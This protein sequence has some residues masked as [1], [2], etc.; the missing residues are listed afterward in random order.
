MKARESGMPD[1]AM[2]RS[3]FAP[4]AILTKLGLTSEIQNVADFGCGYGTFAI[5]AARRI[6]GV[7]FG[8][9]IDAAMIAECEAR[10]CREG[11]R[12]VRFVL[13]DFLADGTGLEPETVEYAMLFNILHVDRPVQLL[14]EAWRI[15][16][17]GGRVA[18]I[19]WNYD[20]HTPRGPSMAI[21]PR[22]ADCRHWI[23]EAGYEVDN[24]IV[25]L[26]P[27]HYGL[28]GRKGKHT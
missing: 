21:R 24:D 8:F 28:C 20:E 11:L 26:P 12:N 18:A 23:E 9:D 13:R 7:L 14:Q 16:V 6:R 5:A 25:N 27:Y 15:L 10:A 1:E 22:P 2:W 4:E 19:H 3:F 17:P